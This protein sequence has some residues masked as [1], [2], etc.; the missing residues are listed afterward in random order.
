MI[1]KLIHDVG[2][3]R[4]IYFAA[5]VANNNQIGLEKY[6]TMEG[7]TYR[8]SFSANNDNSHGINY[9]RMKKNLTQS[10]YNQ[11]IYNESDYYNVLNDNYG[12]YR[13]RNLNDSSIY[14]NDNIQRLVQNYRIGFIRLA[15]YNI[16][17][18]LLKAEP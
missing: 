18:N 15:Q 8:L 7:M 5:T 6:L 9:D 16:D 12:V 17:N 14:F 4:P 3:N 11:I 2:L 10:S 1:L 13:Y